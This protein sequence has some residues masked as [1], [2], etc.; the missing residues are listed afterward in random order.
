M[1]SS[2][3]SGLVNPFYT[4]EQRIGN[5]QKNQSILTAFQI[6]VHRPR[7]EKQGQEGKQQR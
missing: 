6:A 7:K 4:Q 5:Q 1:I 2:R 3:L